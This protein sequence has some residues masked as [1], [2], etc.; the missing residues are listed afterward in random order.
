MADES[1][2]HPSILAVLK[3]GRVSD[4]GDRDVIYGESWPVHGI[5]GDVFEP[6]EHLL[7]DVGGEIHLLEHP[8]GGALDPTDS[9]IRPPEGIAVRVGPCPG[10]GGQNL[11]GLPS[12]GADLHV[13]I[14]PV[15]LDVIP[16]PEL[17]RGSTHAREVKGAGEGRV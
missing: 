15:H 14:V 2:G 12:V 6:Y 4:L 9:G 7:P 13:G 8:V 3:I 10:W 16:S 1:L 5:I 11:P 17:E